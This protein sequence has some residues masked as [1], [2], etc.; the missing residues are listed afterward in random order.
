MRELAM[1]AVDD[2][3][4]LNEVQDRLLFPSQ[5]SV[6]DWTRFEAIPAPESRLNRI[7]SVGGDPLRC[8]RFRP[9]RRGPSGAGPHCRARHDERGT[10]RT[11]SWLH[12]ASSILRATT[13]RRTA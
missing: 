2:T 10:E 4:L 3:P 12:A 6:R 8:I 11:D 9:K 1:G 13:K 7:R 5:L